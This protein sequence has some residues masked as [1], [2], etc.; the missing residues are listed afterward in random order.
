MSKPPTAIV[1]GRVRGCGAPLAVALCLALGSGAAQATLGAVDTTVD[2]DRAA[3]HARVQHQVR[4]SYTVH[5]LTLESRTEVREYAAAGG[6]IFAVTWSGQRIPNLDQLLG[7]HH[8]AA[9]ASRHRQRGGRGHL[10]VQEGALVVES[11]G[12]SPNF[13]GRAY[14]TDS[15]PAGVTA[16]EIE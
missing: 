16:N 10:I 1:T 4:A 5:T 9:M 15:F 7:P 11:N 3:L 2:A 8:A 14:L 6:K 12:R 13:H